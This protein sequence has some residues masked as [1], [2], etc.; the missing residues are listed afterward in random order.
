MQAVTESTRVERLRSHRRSRC[1]VRATVRLAMV[2]T[3]STHASGNWLLVATAAV[4]APPAP[5]EAVPAE[6]RLRANA[7]RELRVRRV[8]GLQGK[9][10]ARRD[11]R[12]VWD[13][14]AATLAESPCG[15]RLMP[16]EG[17]QAPLVQGL[18]TS[19]LP[20]ETSAQPPQH[21]M[22]SL[23]ITCRP[24]GRLPIEPLLSALCSMSL[25][26]S[27]LRALRDPRRSGLGGL[28]LCARHV[29]PEQMPTATQFC[30]VL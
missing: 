30:Y 19:G 16:T 3:G 18:Y 4:A 5:V 21:H 28:F 29:H 20:R 13:G 6:T 11:V 25:L 15:A 2:G 17:N 23:L 9:P 24:F 14:I 27:H 7:V 12:H 22:L 10:R 1:A 8:T 26:F